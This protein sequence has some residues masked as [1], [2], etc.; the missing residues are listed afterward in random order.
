MDLDLYH[1]K[2]EIERQTHQQEEKA[3]RAQ[4]IEAEE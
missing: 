2:M 3:L 1:S 4:V